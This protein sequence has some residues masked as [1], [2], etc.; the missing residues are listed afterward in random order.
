MKPLV[1][2]LSAFLLSFCAIYLVLH[3]WNM[4]LAGN[5]AMSMMLLFTAIRHFAFPTGM[6]EMLPAIIPFKKEIIVLTGILEIAFATG[7]LIPGARHLTAMV[8]IF[9]FILLLSA[10]IFAASKKVNH[11]KGTHDGPGIKYLWF[12]IPLQILLIAWVAWFGL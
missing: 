7:L 11:Q 4:I 1:I 9:F 6:S 2:L 3:Q 8:L 5:I 12:R 10:N